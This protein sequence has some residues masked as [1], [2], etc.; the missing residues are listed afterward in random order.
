M[1]KLFSSC[2]LIISITCL[3]MQDCELKKISEL[4]SSTHPLRNDLRKLKNAI[5][6][7]KL[8]LCSK[9]EE[10][11]FKIFEECFK[12]R[13]G[14]VTNHL[15]KLLEQLDHVNMD[16]HNNKFIHID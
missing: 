5:A 11:G 16:I 1:K 13:D 6:C 9:E 2:C 15:N 4:Q 10:E 3:G 12:W 8:K 7:H 14:F